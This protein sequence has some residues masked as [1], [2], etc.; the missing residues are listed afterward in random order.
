MSPVDWLLNPSGLTPHGFCLSWAPGLVALHAGSDAAIGLAY[1][2]IPL[3]IAAFV[4]QRPDIRYGWVAYL[5]V[6]FILA[7]GATHLMSIFT[8]WVPAYGVEGLIKLATA[9][10]SIATAAILWPLTPKLLAVPSAA[11][12]E[13]LN[14]ELAATVAAQG[15]TAALL[16]ESEAL[17]RSSN[18]ELERR[19]EER[20][21]QLRTA[22]IQLT[23]ALAERAHAEQALAQSEEAF[24]ASFEAAAVGKAQSDPMTGRIIRSNRAFAHMLGYEPEEIVGRSGWEFT[25][26]ED[27]EAEVAEYERV[28]N[29]E[30]PAYVREKRYV[31]RGGEPFWGRVSASIVRDAQTREPVLTVAVIEDID[32]TYKAQGALRAATRELE[33]LVEELTATVSQRDLLL[34]EVYHRVKNNLQIVDSLLVMQARK[35]TD[36]QAKQALQGLRGRIY[37]LGLVHSQLM[38]SKDLKTFD[39]TPFL[40]ELSSHI[41]ESV[42][43]KDIKLTVR[44]IPMDVG[45]DFAIPLGLLVTELVTNSLKHAFPTGAGVIEVSLDRTEGG[46]VLL[47][48]ADDGVGH[49]GSEAPAPGGRTTLG[50]TI[51][52]GLAAQL[53][54]TIMVRRDNG[55]RTEIRVAAPVL[56]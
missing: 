16:R 51:I 25:W 27:R 36:P 13:R 2:S 38:G 15:R 18:V 42:A 14:A 56:S 37:A 29:E 50:V 21:A 30:I 5:F 53:K 24:R 45:L 17:V 22:N 3:A 12:L 23:E 4:K 46:D 10:L 39:I 28:V 34:R 7:C 1:F 26:P 52:E 11:N 49:D 35:L 55:T 31:R 9:I 33:L 47:A 19:V 32:E 8:L 6:A 41:V 20:T 40:Q 54:G 44:A 48:V 43:S